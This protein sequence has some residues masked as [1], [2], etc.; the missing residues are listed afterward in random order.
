MDRLQEAAGD[1]GIAVACDV[2]DA[3]SCRVSIETAASRLG[4][5]DSLVYATGIGILSPLARVDAETWGRLFATN[6]TGAALVTSAALPHLEAARGTAIYLSSI[7][8]SLTPPWPML[9]AYATS[10]AALDKLTEAWRGEHPDVGFTC[11]AVG[12]CAGGEG[13]AATE[14]AGTWDADLF[15]ES[16]PVWL[17][18]GYMTGGLIDAAD[19]VET[20]A[21]VLRLGVS[22]SLP[23]VTLAPRAPAAEPQGG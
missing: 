19:L 5:L 10:K 22:A 15:A 12:D 8:A 16:L 21:A 9:G 3:N 23:T 13:G 2:T 14:F 7:S 6:V 20:V 18:R 11:L 4:G 1:A 17:E